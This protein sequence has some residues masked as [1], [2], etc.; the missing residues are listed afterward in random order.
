MFRVSAVLRRYDADV[1]PTA[2][3]ACCRDVSKDG[4]IAFSTRIFAAGALLGVLRDVRRT[5]HLV[6]QRYVTKMTQ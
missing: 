1:P 3:G 5:L 6:N 2:V 4:L